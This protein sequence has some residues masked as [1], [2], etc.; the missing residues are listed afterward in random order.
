MFCY[1]L[2]LELVHMQSFKYTMLLPAQELRQVLVRQGS[3]RAALRLV[4]VPLI[5]A[6]YSWD[7]G[8]A[9]YCAD[10]GRHP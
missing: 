8:L 1:A 10:R 3:W 4:L 6:L 7:G 9:F 2:L 5:D